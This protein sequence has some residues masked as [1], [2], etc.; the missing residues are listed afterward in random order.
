MTEDSKKQETPT[1]H[2]YRGTGVSLVVK[3][4]E[5]ESDLSSGK[6]R[7]KTLPIVQAG[8]NQYF[9]EEDGV[10]QCSLNKVGPP[11]DSIKRLPFKERTLQ[12]L[13]EEAQAFGAESA[14]AKGLDYVNVIIGPQV[15]PKYVQRSAAPD[16]MTCAVDLLAEDTPMN[17][18]DIIKCDLRKQITPHLLSGPYHKPPKGTDRGNGSTA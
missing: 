11:E 7:I 6:S 14:E 12:K 2:L 5:T 10:I 8:D 17:P 9:L 13:V 4:Y 18:D 16:R 1:H 3:L 15:L